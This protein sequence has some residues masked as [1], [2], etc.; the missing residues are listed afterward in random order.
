MQVDEGD[1]SREMT[2]CLRTVDAV[3]RVDLHEVDSVS[4]EAL[5]GIPRRITSHRGHPISG[6]IAREASSA[7]AAKKPPIHRRQITHPETKTKT[8]RDVRQVVAQRRVRTYRPV[9]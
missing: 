1:C 8:K 9:K 5:R 3:W 7:G 4:R 6:D 2:T